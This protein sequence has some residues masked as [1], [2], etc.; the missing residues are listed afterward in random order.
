LAPSAFQPQEIRRLGQSLDMIIPP[1]LRQ[2]HW[3]GYHRLMKGVTAVKGPAIC[4]RFPV[5]G[6][7]D[8]SPISL[9]FTIVPSRAKPGGLAGLAAIMRDVTKRFDEVRALKQKLKGDLQ[10]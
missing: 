6:K 9:Q 2:R 10:P 7:D 8:G 5:L 4:L 1:R 3:G